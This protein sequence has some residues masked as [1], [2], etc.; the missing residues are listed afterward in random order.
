MMT[1]PSLTDEWPL[2]LALLPADLE[3]SARHFG[4]LRRQR[5][6][7]RGADVVRLALAYALGQRS[8]RATASWARHR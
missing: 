3:Q 8:L 6:F 1:T 4:A 5:A 2:V 7:R